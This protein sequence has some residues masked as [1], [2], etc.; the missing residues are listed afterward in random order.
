MKFKKYMQKLM[1][2][3][4][5]DF[6]IES[7]ERNFLQRRLRSIILKFGCISDLASVRTKVY[8]L[9]KTFLDNKIK[10]NSDIRSSVYYYGTLNFKFVLMFIVVV[11]QNILIY[12]I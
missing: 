12:L 5:E 11:T 2:S 10:P 1:G 3:I 7:I 9:F 4:N 6:W 8:E